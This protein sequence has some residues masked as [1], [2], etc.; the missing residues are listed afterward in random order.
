MAGIEVL[1]FAL[2]NVNRLDDGPFKC[3]M[4][5]QGGNPS[6]SVKSMCESIVR[7]QIAK[8]TIQQLM[9]NSRELRDLLR[10]DL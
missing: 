6:E 1:G 2:W 10:I 4:Y 7:D 9:T 3:I 8:H 5:M